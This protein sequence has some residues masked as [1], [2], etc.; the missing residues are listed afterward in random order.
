VYSML[1]VQS[2]AQKTANLE[3]VVDFIDAAY[4]L[5]KNEITHTTNYDSLLS[6]VSRLD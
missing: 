2:E 6:L 1:H 4:F 3:T 5:F